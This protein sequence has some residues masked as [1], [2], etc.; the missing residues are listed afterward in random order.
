MDRIR[1]HPSASS[2]VTLHTFARRMNGLDPNQELHLFHMVS[3][4]DSS[5]RSTVRMKRSS[6]IRAAGSLG[7][8]ATTVFEAC[9]LYNLS[10]TGGFYGRQL[11]LSTIAR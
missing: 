4:L 10:G 11:R 1:N 6:T 9:G 8:A 5:K 7:S 3:S 2:E